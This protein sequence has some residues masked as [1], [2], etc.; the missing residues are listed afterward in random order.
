MAD[1]R[2]RFIKG[3]EILELIGQ[4]GFGAV[5]RAH[6]LVV[7]REVAFKIILPQYANQPDFIRRF[8]SEAQVVARLEHFH[9]VPLY[10]YWR[11]PDGAYLVMRWLRGGNLRQMLSRQKQLPVETVAQILD[12]IGSALAV[13]HQQGV[14]HRDIKP[15]NILLDEAGNAYLA[16]FGVAIHPFNRNQS[17]QL[18]QRMGSPPYISPEQILGQGALPQSDVYSLGIVLFELLTGQLPFNGSTPEEMMRQHLNEPFPYLQTHRPELPASLNFVLWGATAKSLDA[19]YADALVL[20]REFRQA[21]SAINPTADAAFAAAATSTPINLPVSSETI[22]FGQPAKPINPYKGLRPFQEADALDFF[23]RDDLIEHLLEKLRAEGEKGRFLAVVGPSGSGKSS[24]VKAGLIPALK[25]GRIEH[26]QNWFYAQ[27][28]PGE[29]PFQELESALLSIATNKPTHLL[30]ALKKDENGLFEAL[31]TVLPFEEE[32]FLLVIDQFEELFTQVTDENERLLFL[33]SL[34]AAVTH[35]DSRFRV[36]ITLRADFYDR[37]LLYPGFGDLVRASTE[38]VLPLSSGELVKAIE[39]PAQRVGLFI[40]PSL[41]T[42]IVL[43]VNHEPGALPLLQY[44][45]TELFERHEGNQLTLA[46]YEAIGGLLG[47][48]ARRAD[49]VYESLSPSDQEAARQLFL[50]LVITNEDA[51]KTRRR[52]LQE[53][54]FSLANGKESLFRVIDAFAKYRLLTLDREPS[55]RMPTVE[56]AHEALIR[57]WARLKGW[58]DSNREN[59]LVQR[60]LATATLEWL[61]TGRDASFLASGSRLAQFELL[62]ENHGLALNKDET[63]FIQASLALQQRAKNRTRIF[64]ASLIVFSLVALGLAVFA[65]NAQKNAI[66]RQNE[67]IDVAKTATSRALA[68]TA[69]TNLDHLDLSLLL[70]VEALHTQNTF[71]ARNSLLTALQYRPR[72]KRFLYG[73]GDAVR[74]VAFSADGHLAASGSRDTTVMIWDVDTGQPLFAPLKGHTASINHVAFSPTSPLLASASADGTVRLW[75]TETGMPSGEPLPIGNEA[76]W[77]VAFSPNGHYLAAGDAAGTIRVWNIESR[78]GGEEPFQGHTDIIYSLAFSPDGHYLASAS[79]DG[80][81]RLWDI[82][83][84]MEAGVFQQSDNPVLTVAFSPD[85]QLLAF[86]GAD[87]NITLASVPSGDVMLQIPNDTGGWVRGL[88]FDPSGRMLASVGDDDLVKLWDMSTGQAASEA[89][90]GHTDQVWDVAFSAD[91]DTLASVGRDGRVILWDVTPTYQPLGQVFDGYSETISRVAFSPDS[92]LLASADGYQ[93]SAEYDV[94]LWDVATGSITNMLKGHLGPITDMAFSPDGKFLASASYDQSIR[95][96]EVASGK[97][98]GD[99]LIGPTEGVLSIAISP[100]GNMIAAGYADGSILFWDAKTRIP[101][102]DALVGQSGGV[103]SLAFTPDGQSLAAGGQD[104][105]IMVWNIAAHVLE[106]PP[107]TGHSDA[108]TQIAFS[109]DGK[110]LASGS[111][112]RMIILWDTKTGQMVDQPLIAHTD[113]VL[114]LAFSPDSQLLASSGADK[115]VIV[116]DVAEGQP[117]GQPFAGHTDWVTS[118]AFSPDGQKLA[119]GGLDRKIIVRDVSLDGWEQQACFIANRPLNSKEQETYSISTSEQSI[120]H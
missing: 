73:P 107:L 9:I 79:A 118:V 76:V 95:L 6:Q 89:L 104:G 57:E 2:G 24:V 27:I 44:A 85:S 58:V 106:Y 90:R 69:L 83:T 66:D 18:N 20:A 46:T 23:G 70:S 65:I 30:D 114:G 7:D 12:Q 88:S 13:A 8:E 115:Q 64:I 120:C 98:I 78:A 55:S 14:I 19:R 113:Y 111:R 116:W 3:Y 26:S 16:D 35:P 117:L 96:W 105:S 48:L 119:S 17:P 39:E 72:L 81:V 4:G 86:G 21:M 34:Q 60:R 41:V 54:L 32:N 22:N 71:E 49:E 110:L 102:G 91:G 31:D 29:H 36:I 62:L 45:L 84:G 74:S 92:T 5:Y 97:P 75:D 67:A 77:S 103:L 33:R 109:P 37:P 61:N 82:S 1:F 11:E 42:N 87:Q 99:P 47:A 93:Q 10:D 28:T 80:S 59:L 51:E 40:E 63:D 56:L 50:R 15:D 68:V 94:R 52:V 101:L 38:V 25:K 112:D 43:D 108:V 53:E 100:D